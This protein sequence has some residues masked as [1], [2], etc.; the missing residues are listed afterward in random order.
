MRRAIAGDVSPKSMA[1][2]PNPPPWINRSAALRACSA[3]CAQRTQSSRSKRTPAA[4]AE[5]GS[6]ESSASTR[7]HTSCRS[8]DAARMDT[9][10]EDRP[11]EAGP[12]ISVRQPRGRPPV[13]A[14]NSETPVLTVSGAGL[15][16]QANWPP[17]T[18]ENCWRTAAIPLFAFY[19]PRTLLLQI[20]GRVSTVCGGYAILPRRDGAEMV[21]PKIQVAGGRPQE[22][23]LAVRERSGPARESFSFGLLAQRL[24]P[25]VRSPLCFVPCY[26]VSFL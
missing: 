13:T 24:G 11:D 3:L 18:S 10:R 19:S 17:N 16:C 20:I 9:N 22:A 8:V 15:C 7:A 23:R 21:V 14:S 26:P 4:T 2:S 25:L 5:S 1:T 6:K 12:K